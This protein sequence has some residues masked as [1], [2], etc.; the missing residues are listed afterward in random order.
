MIVCAA[1]DAVEKEGNSP[2]RWV[3][4]WVTEPVVL[5]LFCM[6]G[7]VGWMQKKEAVVE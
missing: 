7:W 1:C 4:G 5:F 2:K 3:G 6:G